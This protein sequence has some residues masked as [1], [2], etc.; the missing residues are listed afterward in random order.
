MRYTHQKAKLTTKRTTELPLV[1][2]QVNELP[3]NNIV[4]N[5]CFLFLEPTHPGTSQFNMNVSRYNRSTDARFPE[6]TSSRGRTE[7]DHKTADSDLARKFF[8]H[9]TMREMIKI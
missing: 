5:C 2:D 6:K 4:D 7:V 8:N 1:T 3:P 9:K